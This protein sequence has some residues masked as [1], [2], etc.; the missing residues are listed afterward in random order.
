MYRFLPV[1]PVLSRCDQS[2]VFRCHGYATHSPSLL[3]MQSGHVL[4]EDACGAHTTAALP[5]RSRT[6]TVEVN[7]APRPRPAQIPHPSWGLFFSNV[8]LFSGLVSICFSDPLCGGILVPFWCPKASK[9]DPKTEPRGSWRGSQRAPS[10][11][12]QK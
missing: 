10:I 2:R 11:K 3:G 9:I 8:W 7:L 4:I 5:P 1:H 12:T 6:R